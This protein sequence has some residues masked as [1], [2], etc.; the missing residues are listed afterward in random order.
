MSKISGWKT[1]ME[2]IQEN[3]YSL[4]R[5]VQTHNLDPVRLSAQESAVQLLHSELGEAVDIIEHE[6][7]ERCLYALNKNAKG[8]IK[9]PKFSG[10]KEEDYL[11]FKADMLDALKHNRVPKTKLVEKLRENLS[12]DPLDIIPK[13]M[14]DLD[15]ALELLRPMYGNSS[16]L[17]KAKREK[18]KAM[19]AMPKPESKAKTSS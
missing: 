2:K 1:R 10:G 16:R 4:Q 18:L 12:G 19:G 11:K 8:D 17:V 15:K 6:N 9:F 3:L 7:E 13:T 14:T 5:I